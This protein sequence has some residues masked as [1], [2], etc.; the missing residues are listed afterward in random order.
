M[1]LP[2]VTG[3]IQRRILANYR[4]NPD[5]ARRVI[6]APFRPKLLH[7]YAIGGICLIRLAEIRPQ[8]LPRALGIQS[9]NCAHR[10]AV[11]WDTPLGPQQGVYVPR[12]DTSSKLN[13]LVGGRVFPGV[14]HRST[15]TVNETAQSFEISVRS[16]DALTQIDVQAHLASQLPTDSVFKTLT[17]ASEFFE[18]GSLGYSATRS[19]GTFDGLELRTAN[20][21]VHPLAVSKV[22]SSFFE[23]NPLIGT[24]EAEFDCALLMRD[25]EHQWHGRGELRA[26]QPAIAT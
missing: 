3:V 4:I 12:R 26:V 6:P 7:G 8:G 1:R 17:E 16:N 10:F 25:I 15:F 21:S 2:V 22:F 23:A 20:W 19:T 13:A 5:A 14:H 9:E 18:A 24:G 11:E